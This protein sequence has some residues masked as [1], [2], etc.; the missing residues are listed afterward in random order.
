MNEIE[1]ARLGY[2]VDEVAEM[3]GVSHTTVRHAITAGQIP[4]IR[5]AKAT[6]IIP[7]DGLRAI[8]DESNKKLK[9]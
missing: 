1:N 9:T 5:I 6:M 4:A 8:M 3:L 7:A 2:R